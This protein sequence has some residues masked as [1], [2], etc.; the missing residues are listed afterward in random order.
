MENQTINKSNAKG[1][2]TRLYQVAFL[3]LGIL[4][5]FMLYTRGNQMQFSQSEFWFEFAQH[6]FIG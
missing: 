4:S 5:L 6:I 1:S 2:S 3:F